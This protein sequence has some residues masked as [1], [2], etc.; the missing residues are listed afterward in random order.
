MHVGSRGRAYARPSGYEGFTR[1][2][3]SDW[4]EFIYEYEEERGLA[5]SD[6]L[7]DTWGEAFERY[8]EE[9]DR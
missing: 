2:D 4:D 7:M 8:G 3:M 6:D 5:P 1:R 9:Y